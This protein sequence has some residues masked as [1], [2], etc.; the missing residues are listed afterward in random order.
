MCALMNVH[1]V[2]EFMCVGAG[3]LRTERPF[4]QSVVICLY[5]CIDEYE[6]V[7]EFMCVEA[8]YFTY[9]KTL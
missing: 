3:Y 2:C 1:N 7:C 5:V 6:H 8:G 9:R 4:E